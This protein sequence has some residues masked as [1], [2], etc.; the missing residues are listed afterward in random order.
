MCLVAFAY[1]TDPRFDLVLIAN[2]DEYFNRPTAPAH[3]WPE[4]PN[5]LA[6]KDLQG[7]G[8][9]MGITRSGRFAL[10]TNYRDPSRFKADAR[11]RGKLVSDFL[12][13]DV[14]PQEYLRRVRS[15]TSHYNDFNLLVGTR[16][17]VFYLSSLPHV[18]HEIASIES[19]IYGMSNHLFET[20]WPK[21]VRAREGLKD[22]LESSL[23]G[24]AVLRNRLFEILRDAT[25]AFDH[26]LPETG[27]GLEKERGLS[28]IFITLP[29]YGTR[30]SSVL[31][32]HKD[33]RIELS[34]RSFSEDR[35]LP[36]SEVAF[37]F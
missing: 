1:R 15:E 17:G 16:D 13:S 27:V 7:G 9:W 31:L 36:P 4:F 12:R 10:L 37:S 8:T 11:S 25:P 18:S 29:G 20:P 24:D 34:E 3:F 14:D 26:E 19:G 28:P 5:L 30:S 6:G 2:R 32:M 35:K 22:A 33:G 23:P 21:V